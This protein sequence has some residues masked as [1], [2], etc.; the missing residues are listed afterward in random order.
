[1]PFKC[2]C[3]EWAKCHSGTSLKTRFPK[4]FWHQASD[5]TKLEH[6]DLNRSL[7]VDF[8]LH[9]WVGCVKLDLQELGQ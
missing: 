9:S 4:E 7:I 8:V 1:M 3:T 5:V 6:A 2:F